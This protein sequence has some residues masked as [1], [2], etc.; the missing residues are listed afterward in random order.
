[1]RLNFT[2]GSMEWHRPTFIAMSVSM[3]LLMATVAV[4]SVSIVF[5]ARM[6]KSPGMSSKTR[7]MQRPL[8]NTLLIQTGAPCLFAFVPLSS[9]ICLPL[10]G[11]DGGAMGTVLIMITVVFPQIDAVIVI[12]FIP[13]FRTAV[14]RLMSFRQESNCPASTVQSDPSLT[15]VKDRP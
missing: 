6:I 13:R 11:I 7:K 4:I 3:M 14:L 10:L 1:E 8:F 5:I 2:T 15:S 12:Y 9:I